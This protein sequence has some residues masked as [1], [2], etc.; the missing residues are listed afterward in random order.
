MAIGGPNPSR[1]HAIALGKFKNFQARTD[2]LIAE[3][4][5]TP[6]V[7]LWSLLYATNSSTV[8]ITNLDSGSEGQLI[9]IINLGSD[10]SFSS[11]QLFTTDSSNLGLFS[12]IDFIQRGANWYETGRSHI[13]SGVQLATTTAAEADSSP[14]VKNVKVLVIANSATQSI[15]GFDD[16]HEGQLLTVICN[17]SSFRLDTG[18]TTINVGTA[19][20]YVVLSNDAIDLVHFNGTWR[21]RTYAQTP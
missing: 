19:G 18:G 10:L 20:A 3:G 11:E 15:D 4:D 6:D 21:V 9:K 14:S 12:S 16:G 5:A 7:S 2:G 8:V 13:G 17:G 1:F